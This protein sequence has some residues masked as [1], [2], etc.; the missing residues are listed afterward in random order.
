MLSRENLIHI[1]LQS[2]HC[3]Q[4]LLILYIYCVGYHVDT[5]T[6]LSISDVFDGHHA[7]QVN[8][9]NDDH[10]ACP[11]LGWISIHATTQGLSSGCLA[12]PFGYPTCMNRVNQQH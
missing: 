11:L 5:K 8:R 1:Y 9:N 7:L 3:F 4:F 12:G 6:V 10:A 2:G